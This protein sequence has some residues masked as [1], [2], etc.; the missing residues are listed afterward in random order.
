MVEAGEVINSSTEIVN[1]LVLQV[2]SLG[3]WLQAVGVIVVFWIGFQ[4]VNQI[5]NR[6]KYNQ[7]KKVNLHKARPCGIIRQKRAV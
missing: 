4:I 7:L 5:L 2:G 3:K 6:K 1:E